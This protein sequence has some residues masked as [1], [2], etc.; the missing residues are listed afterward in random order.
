[1]RR[2]L[3]LV[4]QCNLFRTLL[5]LLFSLLT[6]CAQQPAAT[7]LSAGLESTPLATVDSAVFAISP[8]GAQ[9]AW[10]MAGLRV[11]DGDTGEQLW[12]DART[13]L[14]LAWSDD[15][16]QLAAAFAEG[17]G[18]VRLVLYSPQ[19]RAQ[20]E[21]VIDGAVRGLGFASDGQ[22]VAVVD[23][24]RAYRFGEHREV[25]LVRWDGKSAP[26]VVALGAATVEPASL[27]R[28]GSI[29]AR[30]QWVDFSP[31]GDEIH[32]ARLHDPPAAD[33]Y[34]ELVARHLESG[35]ERVLARVNISSVGGRFF[36]NGDQL[37]Y[38]DG[39]GALRE[40]DL[41]SGQSRPLAF[42]SDAPG[43]IAARS[44]FVWTGGALFEDGRELLRLAQVEAAAFA[45]DGSFYFIRN[46]RLQRLSG[47]VFADAVAVSDPL[48]RLRNWRA[49]GL[50]SPQEFEKQKRRVAP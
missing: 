48:L 26:A 17:A 2:K 10:T 1:M 43:I 45:A 23:V 29:L 6:N 16:R 34:C 35:N 8:A 5:L 39:E 28:F 12:R 30:S 20:Q 44:R 38:D 42:K 25:R 18:Q 3:A 31:W 21:Q 27:A 19:R 7:V 33:P 15:G 4:W 9:T 41:W 13:P 46:D 49:A 50:I 11:A 14:A 36:G 22:V 24:V 47:L 37:V 40:L 32:F